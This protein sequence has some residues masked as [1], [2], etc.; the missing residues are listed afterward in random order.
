MDADDGGVDVHGIGHEVENGQADCGG[1][2]DA[3]AGAE[4]ELHELRQVQLAG[5]R[6]VAKS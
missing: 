5:V 3:H 4:H 2:A 1:L 6:V